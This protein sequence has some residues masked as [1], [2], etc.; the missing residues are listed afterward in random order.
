MTLSAELAE[1]GSRP[2][3]G[4]APDLGGSGADRSCFGVPVGLWWG[5]NVAGPMG[6]AMDNGSC[7]VQPPRPYS[8]IKAG[9][10]G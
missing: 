4:K 9:S 5:L 3:G 7:C 1:G 6:P 8:P 2:G 10:N